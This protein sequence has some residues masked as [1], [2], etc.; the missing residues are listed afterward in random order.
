MLTICCGSTCRAD[1]RTIV[2]LQDL[3]DKLDRDLTYAIEVEGKMRLADVSNYDEVHHPGP[4]YR[5]L[6]CT[7]CDAWPAPQ[8]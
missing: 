2:P 7:A 3:I 1:S 6:C 4:T 8:P 5:P